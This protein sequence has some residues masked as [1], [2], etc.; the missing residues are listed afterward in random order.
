M[1]QHIHS[2]RIYFIHFD[3]QIPQQFLRLFHDSFYTLDWFLLFSF[4][5]HDDYLFFCCICFWQVSR[6]Q[7][8]LL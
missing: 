1:H 6:G 7:G 5:S 3:L 2:I 4:L 8:R